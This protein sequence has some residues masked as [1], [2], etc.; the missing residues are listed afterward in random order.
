MCSTILFRADVSLLPRKEVLRSEINKGEVTWRQYQNNG[1]WR[2]PLVALWNDFT[3]RQKR[4]TLIKC[5]G[6]M[7]IIQQITSG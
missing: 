1:K 6:I 7:E 3:F 4:P 2:L 5:S